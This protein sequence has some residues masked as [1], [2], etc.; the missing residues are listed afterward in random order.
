MQEDVHVMGP[1]NVISGKR[2]MRSTDN[3]PELMEHAEW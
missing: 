2:G 3:L 1:I